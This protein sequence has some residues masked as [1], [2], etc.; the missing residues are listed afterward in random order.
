MQDDKQ[1][2]WLHEATWQQ[3]Y[4]C[5]K[6]FHK[7]PFKQA[8]NIVSEK[9]TLL[10]FQTKDNLKLKT[11]LV[12]FKS[13]TEGKINMR[14]VGILTGYMNGEIYW[15]VSPLNIPPKAR[16]GK[17]CSAPLADLQGSFI[18]QGQLNWVWFY[19]AVACL[20]SVLVAV[21]LLNPANLPD[22]LCCFSPG[23]WV[24]KLS[25]MPSDI[26]H[27]CYIRACCISKKRCLP[28][29]VQV[30]ECKGNGKDVSISILRCFRFHEVRTLINVLLLIELKA[31]HKKYPL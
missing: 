29:E 12:T 18:G 21:D 11:G 17:R 3:T 20:L 31:F 2:G 27:F 23:S 19:G 7:T 30:V 13:R 24:A 25:F 26:I 22:I 10:W 28:S 16:L 8:F 4:D 9:D 1:H 15:K 6:N 5:R 14:L